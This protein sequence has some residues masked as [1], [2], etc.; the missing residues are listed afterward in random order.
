[1]NWWTA[2]RLARHGWEL[3]GGVMPNGNIPA[4]TEAEALRRFG[5]YEWLCLGCEAYAR[6]VN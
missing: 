3:V 2:K 1:M 6:R 5:C 4:A